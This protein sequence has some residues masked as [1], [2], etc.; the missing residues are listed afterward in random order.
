M[1]GRQYDIELGLAHGGQLR[2]QV[3]TEEHP[4]EIHSDPESPT[5]ESSSDPH[6]TPSTSP[7][8][9][10]PGTPPTATPQITLE[11]RLNQLQHN[12]SVVNQERET[13]LASLKS[14]RRDAQKADAALRSEIDT[15]K[16]TS[17]KNS[18]AEL[19]GKQKVL[20]LQEAV[21]RAQNA[22]KE[23][24]E[25]ALQVESEVPGL[26]KR[27]EEKEAEHMRMKAQADKV[28]KKRCSLEE[29]ERK[30]MDAMRAELTGLTNKLERLG[31]KR[32]KLE[33]TVIPDLEEK[34]RSVAQEIEQE[35]EALANLEMEEQPVL[36][37]LG[38]P[39][40]SKGRMATLLSQPQLNSGPLPIRTD[41]CTRIM[42]NPT[43]PNRTHSTTTH[44][45]S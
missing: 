1:P 4:D 36:V 15:L 35:E 29:K 8:R 38:D 2:R 42:D 3:T 20:A 26:T 27:K 10:V 18:A 45:H 43:I 39:A 22:T 31:G 40:P 6:S 17:E 23:T 14:S 44:P 9:T 25:M 30:K 5:M 33:K 12:L 41:Q 7:S 11:D 28:R 34:L 16:R 13:L 32:E 37:L 24:E 21:K 19:R